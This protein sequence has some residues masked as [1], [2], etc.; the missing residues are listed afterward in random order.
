MTH[1]RRQT[2]STQKVSQYHLHTASIIADT[3]TYMR[4]KHPHTSQPNDVST[5]DL[6]DE[7]HRLRTFNANWDQT[8][9]DVK[10]LANEGFFSFSTTNTNIQCFSCGTILT[11]FPSN[12]ASL[13][14]H[15]LASPNCKHLSQS[16]ET[17]KTDDTY[18]STQL[19]KLENSKDLQKNTPK[20]CQNFLIKEA[21]F[22]KISNLQETYYKCFSCHGI[23][24]EWHPTDDPCKLHA[25][26]FTYCPHV[27]NWKTKVFVKDILQ[28]NQ[29]KPPKYAMYY[30]FL[31][32]QIRC[33][34]IELLRLDLGQLINPG[35]TL[36]LLQHL[37]MKSETFRKVLQYFSKTPPEDLQQRTDDQITS[38]QQRIQCI[39]APIKTET[40]YYFHVNIS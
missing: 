32:H 5:F 21:G 15:L 23:H 30:R 31:Q 9:Y 20:K 22:T 7:Q 28:Q 29:H 37:N 13:I 35:N 12:T 39:I 17:N 6:T 18:R 27:T 33:F 2:L 4:L 25:R 38:M 3:A 1:D 19:H 24:N 16:D 34:S 26:Y 10:D 8:L 40:H 14:I 11:K 36:T